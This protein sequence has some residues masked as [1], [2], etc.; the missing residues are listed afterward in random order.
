MG[1]LAGSGVLILR[2][3]INRGR[4][5]IGAAMIR[6]DLS[7]K[8]PNPRGLHWYGRI[9]KETIKFLQFSGILSVRHQLAFASLIRLIRSCAYHSV[10]PVLILKADNV[11][12]AQIGPNLHLDQCQWDPANILQT[13]HAAEGQV[14]T[15]VFT[16]QN[17]LMVSRHKSGSTYHNPMFSPMEV[18]LQAQLLPHVNHDPLHLVAAA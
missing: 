13:V 2:T 18:L 1:L 12:L 17:V 11:V 10:S 9:I 8:M 6:R 14:D 3:D 5:G 7:Q 4:P 15:L 16:N